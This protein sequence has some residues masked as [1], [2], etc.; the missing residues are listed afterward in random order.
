MAD[1]SVNLQRVRS[2]GLE[3]SAAHKATSRVRAIVRQS[4]LDQIADSDVED[5]ALRDECYH[6]VCALDALDKVFRKIIAAGELAD[7]EIVQMAKIAKG[8]VK[9]FF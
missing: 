8:E 9:D 5:R 3:F 6:R 4:Y 1:E 7:A 2:E